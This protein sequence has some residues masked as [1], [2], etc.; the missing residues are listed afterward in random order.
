MFDIEYKGANAVIFTTKKTKV[1]FDPGLSIAGGKDLSVND[2]VVVLTEDRLGSQTGSPALLFDGPGEY[3]TGGISITGVAA[4]RNIDA[5]DQGLKSTAYRMVIEGTRVAVVG[6][7]APGLS[8]DQLEAIGV[9][10]ILVVP[11]GG[12]GL[13]LDAVNASKVVRQ[14][15][16]RAIIPV[17]YADSSL[18]YEVPQDDMDIFVKEMGVNVVEAGSKHKIK[19]DSSVPDQMTI[20]KIA[21]S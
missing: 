5:E 13:T 6:N 1:M 20:I 3:E 12:G 17:H 15:E 18:N 19:G 10:D 7:I 16:P 8:D 21:R 14:I 9:V 2:S 11:I 4:R